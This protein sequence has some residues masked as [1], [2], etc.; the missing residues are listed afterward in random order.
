[1]K[2]K[3][4]VL[5]LPVFC[6]AAV[7][8]AGCSNKTY[9][10]YTNMPQDGYKITDKG[11]RLDGYIEGYEAASKNYGEVDTSVFTTINGSYWSMSAEAVL[12]VSD[13]FTTD[14]AKEKGNGFLGVVQSKL[15][16][17]ESA[18]SATRPNSDIS[19]FNNA[20]QGARI[21]I[22]QITYEDRKSVV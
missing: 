20:A 7:L 9:G 4:K 18:L 5:L 2:N 14:E 11:F 6:A 12:V 21:E 8:S 19:N 16:E 1:M 13:D 10:V 17:I 22:K 15:Y 3:F